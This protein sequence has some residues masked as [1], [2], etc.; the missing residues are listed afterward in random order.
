MKKLIIS[1]ANGRMGREI[2]RLC[3]SFN[4]IP[5]A[6]IDVKN[7]VPQD[8]P[9]YSSYALC[10][11]TADLLIDFSHAAHLPQ[12]LQFAADRRIPV[13]IGTTGL[14]K[15]QQRLIDQAAKEIPVMQSANFSA[16]ILA[17]KK[18]CETAADILR[19]FD[20][21]IIDR[22]HAQKADAPGGTAKMLVNVLATASSRPIYGR[23]AALHKRD[24]QEIG[25]HSL[26]G[27]TLCGTHEVG[28]YGSGEHLLIVHVAEDRSIFA[29]GA[30][31]CGQWLLSQPPGRYSAEDT[32][33]KRE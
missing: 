7:T 27:G 2:V 3:P 17:L 4:F 21:E 11:E 19:N 29:R 5:V 31:Q 10:R 24:K 22:H 32:Q 6:G 16:G 25:V 8:F 28:F 9:I 14:E 23:H 30:L 26:R 20:V 13:L 1:G 33:Q 18:L 15:A 12:T